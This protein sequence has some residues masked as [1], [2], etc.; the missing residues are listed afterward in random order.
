MGCPRTAGS[1]V[2]FA[3]TTVWIF[4]AGGA[5]KSFGGVPRDGASAATEV[6]AQPLGIARGAIAGARR[7]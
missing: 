4:C 1:P 7:E 3:S 2:S 6:D 5:V